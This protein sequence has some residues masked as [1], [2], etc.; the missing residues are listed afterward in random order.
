MLECKTTIGFNGGFYHE[1]RLD[2]VQP[3]YSAVIV[4]RDWSILGHRDE[5]EA[6]AERQFCRFALRC[7]RCTDMFLQ[8]QH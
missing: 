8:L 3:C 5:N 7:L 4:C 2:P 1:Q 6:F